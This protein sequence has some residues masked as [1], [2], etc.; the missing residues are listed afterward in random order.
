MKWWWIKVLH[1]NVVFDSLSRKALRTLWMLHVLPGLLSK[2]DR[3]VSSFNTSIKLSIQYSYGYARSTSRKMRQ[4]ES[5]SNTDQCQSWIL[6]VFCGVDQQG[7]DAVSV[8]PWST[9]LQHHPTFLPN[10]DIFWFRFV[11][12]SW[13]LSRWIRTNRYMNHPA[14]HASQPDKAKHTDLGFMS[15]LAVSQV[16]RAPACE[17]LI[18]FP[19]LSNG[20]WEAS[21]DYWVVSQFSSLFLCCSNFDVEMNWYLFSRF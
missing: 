18:N 12:S 14:W 17:G 7:V 16:S 9:N 3:H 5:R 1:L 20:W 11:R 19:D 13:Q 4:N 15:V 6:D 10:I 21:R 2:I 8:Q